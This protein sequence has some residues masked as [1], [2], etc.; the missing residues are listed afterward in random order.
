MD[1]NAGTFTA[2]EI[3][4]C[5]NSKK[6]V[7]EVKALKIHYVVTMGVWLALNIKFET[8]IQ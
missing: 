4:V 3:I 1:G 7:E 6:S 2:F 8:I 5:E